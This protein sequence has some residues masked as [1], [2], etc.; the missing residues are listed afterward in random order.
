MPRVAAKIDSNQGAVVKA[1][2]QIGASVQVLSQVGKGCP[3]V[4]VGFR[5]VNVLVEIKDGGKVPSARK[6]TSDQVKW[7]ESWAGQVCVA[8]DIRDAIDQVIKVAG[9]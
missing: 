6:L 5:G 4:L 8:T 9:L 7:H 3:D 2:R 1:F